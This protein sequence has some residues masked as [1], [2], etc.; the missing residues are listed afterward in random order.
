[1]CADLNNSD[2]PCSRL[3][4]ED[5]PSIT[6]EEYVKFECSQFL[7][8]DHQHLRYGQAFANEFNIHDPDLFYLKS[9]QKAT[10]II[11]ENYIII[12]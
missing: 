4:R 10:E 8:K 1:M 12:P 9:Q 2:T 11:M 3:H 5:A 7:S 6:L